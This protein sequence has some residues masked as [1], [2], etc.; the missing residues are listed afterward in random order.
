MTVQQHHPNAATAPVATPPSTLITEHEVR[1]ATAAA[2]GVTAPPAPAP[3]GDRTTWW[4]R[5]WTRTDPPRPRRRHY[6]A[7]YRFLEDAAMARGMHRL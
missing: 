6:P 2:A 7:R 4:Q 3:T 5:L 1:L